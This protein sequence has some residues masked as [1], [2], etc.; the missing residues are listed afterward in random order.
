[1]YNQTHDK[2]FNVLHSNNSFFLH[3]DLQI[4]FEAKRGGSYRGDIA[5]DNVQLLPGQCNNSG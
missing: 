5:I 1:M 3:F 2:I 4:L